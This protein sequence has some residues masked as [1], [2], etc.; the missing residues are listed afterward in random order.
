MGWFV[1]TWSGLEE[2][3]ARHDRGGFSANE[4]SIR[5]LR[6]V[7]VYIAG[8]TWERFRVTF[9]DKDDERLMAIGDVEDASSLHGPRGTSE[10]TEYTQLAKQF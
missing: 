4:R 6:I 5:Q 10:A 9:L 1:Y 2:R 8:V 3:L 7:Y